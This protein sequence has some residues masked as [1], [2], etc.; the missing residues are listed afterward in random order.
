MPARSPMDVRLHKS[1]ALLTAE[2]RAKPSE[3]DRKA[4]SCIFDG[5]ISIQYLSPQQAT[6]ANMG[7]TLFSP[8]NSKK[9]NVD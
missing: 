6:Q 9:T 2:L 3:G 5:I 1:I 7:V 4:A 8:P